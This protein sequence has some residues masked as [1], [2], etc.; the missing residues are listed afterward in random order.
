MMVKFTI[1]VNHTG[2]ALD[3]IYVDPRHSNESNV[4][5][6]EVQACLLP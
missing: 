1:V 3:D 2:H 4:Q 5:K 6:T